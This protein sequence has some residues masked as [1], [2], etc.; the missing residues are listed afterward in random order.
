[1]L[2]RAAPWL[3]ELKALLAL[4]SSTVLDLGESKCW[5]MAW[6]T[7]SMPAICHAHN[8][9]APADSRFFLNYCMCNSFIVCFSIVHKVFLLYFTLNLSEFGQIRLL[10][11]LF[12]ASTR[13]FK[14]LCPSSWMKSAW[15]QCSAAKYN[16]VTAPA[17][18]GVD[19]L[20]ITVDQ[21]VPHGGMH[22]QKLTSEYCRILL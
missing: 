4:T 7:N 9:V 13:Y 8:W 19:W 18:A 17:T 12:K 5:R 15:R 2:C 1:M 16:T 10:N 21:Y 3:N 14:C 22:A 20:S 11:T 6:T